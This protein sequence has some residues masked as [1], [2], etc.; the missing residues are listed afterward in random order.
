[1]RDSIN[2][3]P[4]RIEGVAVIE[5]LLINDGS[6]DG[7]VEI[8]RQLNVDHILDFRTHRGLAKVF[9]AGLRESA[10]LGASFVVNLDADN[11]YNADDIPKLLGP[12]LEGR[13]DIVVGERPIG[14]IKHFSAAKKVFQH[15]GSWVVKGLSKTDVR[16]SPSGFRAFNRTAMQRLFIFGDYT[17]THESLIAA[18]ESDLRVLLNLA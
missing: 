11:Q 2:A 17:Y 4:K 13:A 10:R 3:L 14:E 16:D 9:L 18:H 8:A 7:T 1:M 5:V 12:L 15:F 6:T